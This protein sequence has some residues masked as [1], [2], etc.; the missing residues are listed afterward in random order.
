MTHHFIKRRMNM[1][2]NNP[3]I[4]EV[5]Y[6]KKINNHCEWYY[7]GEDKDEKWVSLTW[8]KYAKEFDYFPIIELENII[9]IDSALGYKDLYTIETFLKIKV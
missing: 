1:G 6:I 8:K 2:I 4:V 3:N 9:D 7:T 5:Y